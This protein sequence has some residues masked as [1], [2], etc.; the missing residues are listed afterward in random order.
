MHVMDKLVIQ[1]IPSVT[2]DDVEY[3]P[4]SVKNWLEEVITITVSLVPKFWLLQ[5]LLFNSI[6]QKSKCDLLM[7]DVLPSVYYR[8]ENFLYS[9]KWK[10]KNPRIYME[11]LFA[12]E[13]TSRGY[14]ASQTII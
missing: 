4:N 1:V 7:S 14:V 2:K 9:E 6:E 5:A 8:K 3:L 12:K 13:G 11:F 10:K